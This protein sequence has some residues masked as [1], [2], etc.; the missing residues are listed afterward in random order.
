MAVS[1]LVFALGGLAV[2]AWAEPV[3]ARPPARVERV[4]FLAGPGRAR[5]LVM[6]S[7]VVPFEVT[8]I[9]PREGHDFRLV[10]DFANARLGERARKPEGELSGELVALR[11]GQFNPRT[12]RVVLELKTMGAHAAISRDNPPRVV[13]DVEVGAGGGTAEAKA[14]PGRAE[15]KAGQATAVPIPPGRGGGRPGEAPTAPPG[16][17]PWIV[18]I[19]PGHGGS[20]PGAIGL[21]GLPEKVVT[22]AVSRKLAALLNERPRVRAIL[23][24]EADVT[25]ALRDRTALANAQRADIFISIHTN[26]DDKG[27]LSG[28]ETYYLNNADDHATVRLAAQENGLVPPGADLPVDRDVLYIVS[29]LIQRGKEEESIALAGRVQSSLTRRLAREG[30]PVNDL[31]VKKGPFF[32]LT[33]AYMPCVLVE[34]SFISHPREGQLL[35]TEA[36]QQAVA[37]GI[38]QGIVEFLRDAEALKT[39]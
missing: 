21:G 10:V 31:G 18:V 12:A 39:L 29:D 11:T 26:A 15:P 23:T 24:R 32:V 17:S 38:Y 7:R 30:G 36:Y 35:G 34:I 3:P 37:E 28:I 13:I 14:V 22:L 33:G 9:E 16:Q 2:A 27:R 25:L 8:R 4:R 19:D 6:L 20:D 5:V 1:L